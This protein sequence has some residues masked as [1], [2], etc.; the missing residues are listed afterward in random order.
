LVSE[1]AK[2]VRWPTKVLSGRVSV[3]MYDT[4]MKI[5]YTGHYA[6]VTDYLRTTKS[7]STEWAAPLPYSAGSAGRRSAWFSTGPR[8]AWS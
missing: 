8:W 6:D 5:V 3:K 4:V 1:G 2:R 7:I